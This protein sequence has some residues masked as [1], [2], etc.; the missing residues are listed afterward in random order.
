MAAEG[1]L[2]PKPSAANSYPHEMDLTWQTIEGKK[3]MLQ[4]ESPTMNTVL[5]AER[6]GG[7]HPVS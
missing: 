4:S 7:N 2:N 3:P 6:V 5:Q 1:V